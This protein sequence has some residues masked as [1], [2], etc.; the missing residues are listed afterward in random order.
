[1]S[2]LRNNIGQ[3][4]R[5]HIAWIEL[6]LIFLYLWD[7]SKHKPRVPERFSKACPT[8]DSCDAPPVPG[9]PVTR[10]RVPHNN[11]HSQLVWKVYLRRST[12][13]AHLFKMK[14]ET[15]TGFSAC[16]SR[17]IPASLMFE[18]EL[19]YFFS[20]ELT[21]SATLPSSVLGTGYKAVRIKVSA[22]QAL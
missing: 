4:Q 3:K 8:L 22:L 7:S 1:M 6:R 2:K 13:S 20:K 10:R 16:E 19:T 14:T 17:K 9:C 21:I 12:F 11:L 15:E 5:A 18:N